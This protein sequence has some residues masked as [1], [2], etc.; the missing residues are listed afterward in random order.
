MR[1]AMMNGR[2]IVALFAVWIGAKPVDP[3]L[4]KAL[5]AGGR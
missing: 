2:K 1:G 3:E 5:L 4:E